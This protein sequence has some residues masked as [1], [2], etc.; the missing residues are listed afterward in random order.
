MVIENT[1]FAAD[2]ALHLPDKFHSYYDKNAE[3]QNILESSIA[4]VIKTGLLDDETAKAINLVSN[5]FC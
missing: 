3:W 4:F 5:Q 2:V 1:A